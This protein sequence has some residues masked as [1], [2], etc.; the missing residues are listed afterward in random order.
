M[1]FQYGITHAGRYALLKPAYDEEQK[2]CSPGQLL[3]EQV[4]RDCIDRGLSEFD[5]LGPHMVWKEDWTDR[6]REHTWLYL[7]AP[8]HYGRMLRGYR[9]GLLPRLKAK[10]KQW[11]RRS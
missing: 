3:M 11:H 10:V 1:A 2:E 7:F 4:L 6:V 5:F 8:S 9:F